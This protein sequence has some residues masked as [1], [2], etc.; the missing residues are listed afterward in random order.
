[1]YV[2]AVWRR[3]RAL[4][5]AERGRKENCVSLSLGDIHTEKW[6]SKLGVGSN[7]DELAP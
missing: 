1:M 3:V 7:A 4:A 2:S 6:S 5:V